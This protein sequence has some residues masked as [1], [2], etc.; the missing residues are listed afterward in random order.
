MIL[1]VAFRF[2]RQAIVGIRS[3]DGAVGLMEDLFHLFNQ[4]SD[5]FDQFGLISIIFF[6][7]FEGFYILN[8]ASKPALS[9]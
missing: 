7:S 4:R 9:N 8:Q 5:L 2:V 1:H 3:F 6:L